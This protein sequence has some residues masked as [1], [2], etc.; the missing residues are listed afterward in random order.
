MLFLCNVLKY[1][2][3][4]KNSLLHWIFEYK[5]QDFSLGMLLSYFRNVYLFFFF[6]KILSATMT[7]SGI[8]KAPIC[9]SRLPPRSRLDQYFRF[10]PSDPKNPSC[11]IFYSGFPPRTYSYYCGIDNHFLNPI[12]GYTV[13]D[14][15]LIEMPILMR[16]EFDSG[17]PTRR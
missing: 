12:F 11:I 5:F 2:N 13:P 14:L 10:S 15:S 4:E 9:Q 1:C 8:L 7:I 3:V 17:L 6:S 16:P